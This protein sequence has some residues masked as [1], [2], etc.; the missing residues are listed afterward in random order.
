MGSQAEGQHPDYGCRH[1]VLR[2]NSWKLLIDAAMHQ[3]GWR[4]NV[5]RLARIPGASTR[6]L[7]ELRQAERE[8]FDGVSWTWPLTTKRRTDQ[9]SG[10]SETETP[11]ATKRRDD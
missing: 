3:I 7:R 4:G 11:T 5:G 10:S 1:P 8:V 9:E 6:Y 2:K